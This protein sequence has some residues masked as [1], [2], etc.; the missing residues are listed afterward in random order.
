MCH[1]GKLFLVSPRKVPF[2]LGCLV[3]ALTLSPPVSGSDRI[4]NEDTG[5]GDIHRYSMP[6]LFKGSIVVCRLPQRP[7]QVLEQKESMPAW[8]YAVIR[9]MKPGDNCHHN[10]DGASVQC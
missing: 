8:R 6:P 4:N 3:A 5:G 10:G 7:G 1:S 9:I 2:S